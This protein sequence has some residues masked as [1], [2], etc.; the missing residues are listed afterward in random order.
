MNGKNVEDLTPVVVRSLEVQCK[1]CHDTLAFEALGVGISSVRS[2]FPG[3]NIAH[4]PG[5]V[6]W[7]IQ[8]KYPVILAVVFSTVDASMTL[9][10]RHKL[11]KGTRYLLSSELRCIS[12]LKAFFSLNRKLLRPTYYC[13]ETDSI[14]AVVQEIITV[15]YDDDGILISTL[16]AKIVT[17]FDV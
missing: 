14:L 16:Q 11:L 17:R 6:P 1:F 10:M 12:D 2:S 5:D 7:A 4:S 13:I 9:G 3:Q 8:P 15:A